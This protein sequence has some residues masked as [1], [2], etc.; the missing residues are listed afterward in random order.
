MKMCVDCVH[1]GWSPDEPE[2]YPS[3]MQC[4]N[5]ESK[6]HGDIVNGDYC[7]SQHEPWDVKVKE[8]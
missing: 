5:E 7:C 1:T 2:T 3:E 8:G 4:L 6:A